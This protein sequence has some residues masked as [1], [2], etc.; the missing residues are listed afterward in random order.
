[1][2]IFDATEMTTAVDRANRNDVITFAETASNT[3]IKQYGTA[4]R[5]RFNKALDILA[6]L[7]FE[8]YQTLGNKIL[9]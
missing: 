5:S 2:N 6:D 4:G 9:N 7:D 1:M 8:V 3:E